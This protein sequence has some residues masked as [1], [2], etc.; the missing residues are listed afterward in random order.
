LYAHNSAA[1]GES[2]F[3]SEDIEITLVS[4]ETGRAKLAISAPIDVTIVRAELIDPD[5]LTEE[6]K[7]SD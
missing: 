1:D 5:E 3:I 7:E 2:F 6:Q 4:S